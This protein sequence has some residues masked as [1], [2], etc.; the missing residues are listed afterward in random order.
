M[1]KAAKLKQVKNEFLGDLKNEL[2]KVRSFPGATCSE[3]YHYLAPILERK[4]DDV[5]FH[6]GTND[7]AHYEGTEVLDKLLEL[8]PFIVEQLPKTHIVISHPITGTDSEHLAM[9]K[10]IFNH[11][12]VYC[13]ST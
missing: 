1:Y 10:E 4:P 8:K 11:I 9:K 2:I 12:L 13:K 3:M 7:V 6:V 5:I